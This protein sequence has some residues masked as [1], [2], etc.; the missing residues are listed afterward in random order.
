MGRA[1]SFTDVLEATDALSPDEQ[2]T[3]VDVLR[4]RLAEQR[5]EQI[6]REIQQARSE[7]QADHCDPVTPDELMDEI[8]K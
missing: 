1:L 2:Q 6:A 4:R 8:L 3:L 5:R 7:F